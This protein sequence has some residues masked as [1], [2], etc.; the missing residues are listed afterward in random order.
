MD[1][2]QIQFLD[3]I[4]YI[5]CKQFARITERTHVGLIAHTI[6]TIFHDIAVAAS[7]FQNRR[8]LRPCHAAIGHAMDQQH[9]LTVLWTTFIIRHPHAGIQI[10]VLLLPVHFRIIIICLTHKISLLLIPKNYIQ[11]VKFSYFPD[12]NPHVRPSLASLPELTSVPCSCDSD[13]RIRIPEKSWFSKIPCCKA[14]SAE[15]CVPAPG[16][17]SFWD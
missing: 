17:T 6:A 7:F 15:L 12:T 11:S 4:N 14:A 13:Q 3:K 10:Q 9:R 2:L 8:D 1:F 5:A 16:G